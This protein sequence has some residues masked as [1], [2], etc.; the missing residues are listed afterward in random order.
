[1]NGIPSLASVKAFWSGLKTN[2]KKGLNQFFGT[3]SKQ[4]NER[5]EEYHKY[6]SSHL[7]KRKINTLDFSKG[8]L[9]DIEFDSLA[10]QLNEDLQ[11]F[12]WAADRDLSFYQSSTLYGDIKNRVTSKL[13]LSIV[14]RPIQ[15]SIQ[16]WSDLIPTGA[17]FHDARIHAMDEI[18]TVGGANI[19]A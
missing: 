11:E 17:S 6:T 10:K 1:M 5:F 15:I 13:L 8:A 4:G 7:D 12:D 3:L 19:T 18:G 16:K 2:S 14:R 9:S